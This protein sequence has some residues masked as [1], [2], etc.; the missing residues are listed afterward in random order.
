MSVSFQSM[1]VSYHPQG[2][3]MTT[4]NIIRGFYILLALYFAAV[5]GVAMTTGLAHRVSLGVLQLFSVGF[6]LLLVDYVRR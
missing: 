5:V 4:A 1:S 2:P 6:I 3:R